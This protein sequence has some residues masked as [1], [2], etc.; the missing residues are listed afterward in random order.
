MNFEGFYFEEC[1]FQNSNKQK[2]VS[3][4]MKIRECLPKTDLLME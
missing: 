3:Q 4:I 2:F 1:I